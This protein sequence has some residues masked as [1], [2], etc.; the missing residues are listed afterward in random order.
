M[1]A[2]LDI[3]LVDDQ[4]E[5]LLALEAIL[6]ELGHN[7]IRAGSGREA[8]RHLL[9]RD[10]ALI[11]LDVY[12]P[13]MDG[14]ETARLI[15]ERERSHAIPIIFLTAAMNTEEMVFKGYSAGAV[16]YLIKPLVPEILRAKVAV[17]LELAAARQTLE[18]EIAE[19]RRAE[20]TA[21][22]A[23]KEAE[24]AGRA[25]SE[26]LAHMSHEIRTPMNGVMGMT[27]LALDTLLTQ[28]QRE[29]LNMVKSS[30]EALL[31][32]LDDILDFSKIEA[33]KLN[34]ERVDFALR[35]TLGDTLKAL[36]GRAQE[37]GTKLACHFHP[38]VPDGLAG[39][40]FR[41]RQVIVNLVGNAIKFTDQGEIVVDVRN[42][43]SE[44]EGIV[45]RFSVAD[46]GIGIAPDK[47]RLIFEA[48]TQAD[49]STTRQYGGTGLGLTISSKLVAMMG[50]RIWVESEQGK[51]STFHFTADFRAG[52]PFP[53]VRGA[54]HLPNLR[55]L[56]VLVVD[57]NATNRRIF[58][59]TL[60]NWQ[61]QP[62][63]A[64]SGAEAL[65]VM[66]RGVRAG[67]PFALVLLDY[68]M[69][70]M[71]GFTLAEKIKADP[72]LA[73]A[74]LVMLSSGGHGHAE[75]RRQ[76]GIAA[77]LMKPVKQSELLDTIVTVLGLDAETLPGTAARPLRELLPPLR[78]LLAEDNAV[79]QKFATRLL[80]KE[81]HVVT[82]APNGRRALAAVGEEPFDLVLMDIQMTEMDGLDATTAI[83]AREKQTGAHLP[84]IALTAHAMKGDRERCLAAG[85]DG[86]VTK[87]IR[88]DELWKAIAAVLPGRGK[89][90]SEARGESS[91]NAPGVATS[92]PAATAMMDNDA[93][94]HAE[95][96]AIF[97]EESVSLMTGITE[98]I[99]AGNAA[100]LRCDAH[101]LKGAAGFFDA[102]RVGALAFKLERMGHENDL[103]GAE[104][105][106]TSLEKELQRL[107][108]QLKS[109]AG[110]S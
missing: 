40:P 32:V 4:P 14:F 97:L 75:Q 7:L 9:A 79:N 82:V 86:Y 38:D 88:P 100:K 71:D 44:G 48:F 6:G 11:L 24:H 93:R 56:P 96:A 89:A 1:G 31:S 2:P 107:G 47:Q 39:D 84:I 108:P 36:G 95:L 60:R 37:K 49:T 69:P 22:K 16:D 63:L 3:L 25:K 43:P 52:D 55:D 54:I 57:D 87:P 64:E 66:R 13:G 50:G 70:H 12:M 33:G 30:A 78:I 80:E 106:C 27:A 102:A 5:N 104:E 53:A 59:E 65:Q 94:E 90:T 26:F 51:G 110:S 45:L 98:A 91:P 28:E 17:F 41:L 105:T 81:G 67:E 15:R 76:I 29:Y 23:R 77:C 83:R 109:L 72:Q 20:E 8:L 34:L 19:R 74:P 35:E 92:T 58:E 73:A 68:H 85:M 101:S 99:A 42:E 18:E 10:A 21:R 62:T 61:M 46:S 103:A